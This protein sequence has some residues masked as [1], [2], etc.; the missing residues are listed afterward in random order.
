MSQIIE[1]D[2]N[3]TNTERT[4]SNKIQ[5]KEKKKYDPLEY[6]VKDAYIDAK[7]SMNNWCH[8]Q[9]IE[10]CNDDLT[11]RINFDGWSH[12]WDEVRFTSSLKILKHIV[13]KI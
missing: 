4:D 10:R 2:Q 7:D 13:G 6:Y 1:E 3:Q 5:K 9:I 12:K 8:G 11:L